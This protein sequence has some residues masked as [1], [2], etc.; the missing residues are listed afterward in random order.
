M[1]KAATIQTRLRDARLKAGMSVFDLAAKSGVHSQSIYNYEAGA[2]NPTAGNLLALA[3]AL[4]VTTDHL[5]G[6][7]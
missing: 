6:K 7:D 2:S 1:K 4:S 3:S 5:L